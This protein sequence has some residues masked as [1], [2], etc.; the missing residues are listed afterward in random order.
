MCV[1]AMPWA[2]AQSW[3][4]SKPIE[5]VVPFAAGGPTDALGRAVASM[6]TDHGW[7]TVVLNRPGADGVL[8]ANAVA[9]SQSKGHTL[10]VAGWGIMDANLAVP[11][12]PSGIAYSPANFKE[13]AP[14]GYSSLVLLANPNLPITN[15]EDFKKWVR[16]NPKRFN[17]GFFNSQ[18]GEVFV[19]WAELEKLPRPNVIP[20]KGSVPMKTD[21]TG[22]SLEFAFDSYVSSFPQI[23]AG[24]L[25][26]L[27]VYDQ[28]SVDHVRRTS[29]NPA[30]AD[31]TR[32]HPS[33]TFYLYT[34]VFA[35]A[36]TPD[37][38]I[39][40][41]NAVINRGL[42]NPKYVE[43]FQRNHYTVTGGTPEELKQLHSRQLVV[44]KG[45]FGAQK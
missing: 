25:R 32:A 37:E 34:G 36:D 26:L 16:Q 29:K 17:L 40:E 13:V 5:I 30:L 12:P 43:G 33:V 14:I 41:M 3:K 9:A 8:G 19:K 39:R 4:P 18:L 44:L 6:L 28:R 1:F 42:K 38:A 15:Y 45:I 31:L 11:N 35:A 21:L 27:G 23:D 10:M 2:Q 7:E 22:G 24:Q 20:Y